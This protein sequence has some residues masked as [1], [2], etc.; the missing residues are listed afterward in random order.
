MIIGLS[1]KIGVGKS[2]L[3]NMFLKKY[4]KYRKLSFAD[5]LKKECSEIFKY[6]LEWNYSE[7]GKQQV[8]RYHYMLP[9]TEMTIREILQWYGTD[10]K[11]AQNENYWVEKMEEKLFSIHM[12]PW[13][14]VIDDIRFK[15]ECELVKKYNGIMIRINPY[16]GWAPRPGSYHRSEID[17][18]DY[19]EWDLILTPE[20]GKLKCYLSYI[21]KAIKEK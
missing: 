10:L 20:F 12:K 18:D 17:L 6:P 1:G 2:C 16:P 11:R 13:N 15:N 9:T 4:P 21:E 5:V 14:I 19:R 3:A 8:V 7:E